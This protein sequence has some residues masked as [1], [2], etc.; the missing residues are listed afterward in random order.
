M[1]KQRAEAAG[2]VYVPEPSWWDKFAQKLNASVPVAQE[3]EIELDH[4]YDGIKELDNHLPPWWKWLFYVS[5]I[6]AVIYIGIYHFAYSLPLSREEYENEVALAT[7]EQQRFEASQPKAAIDESTLVY[8][9][10]A[11]IIERGKA[12]FAKNTCASCHRNDGGGNSIGPNLTDEYWL[13]GGGIKNVFTTIKNGVVEKGMP[14]WGKAM[15]P[16]DVRDV[17]FF[18]LSLQGTKP[19]NPK[20]PQG[21]LY[22]P[23]PVTAKPD[24][25]KTT[26]LK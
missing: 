26:A 1:E 13:H 3:K 12:V 17:T 23:E 4:N 16:S 15:K 14:A 9:A 7:E 10:D 6:W 19:T 5:I 2:R 24:S 21:E 8:N 11:T 20:A 18:V 25:S 22:K